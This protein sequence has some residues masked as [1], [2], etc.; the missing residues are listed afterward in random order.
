MVRVLFEDFS[1]KIKTQK[2]IYDK[3]VLDNF[4]I[5]KYKIL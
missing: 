1:F 5:Y 2:N 4:V 3:M